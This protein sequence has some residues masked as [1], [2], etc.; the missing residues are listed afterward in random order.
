MS[1]NKLLLSITASAFLLT[2]CGPSGET[3]SQESEPG[4]QETSSDNDEIISELEERI[5]DLEEANKELE[6]ENA[7]LSSSESDEEDGAEVVEAG[8]PE[9]PEADDESS[10]SSENAGTRS[11]PIVF[12][13]EASFFGTFADRDADY[14][15]FDAQVDITVVDTIRGEEA[16]DI[17]INENQFNDPAPEGK[18]YMI[19]RIR[20]KLSNATSDD[21]K[22][23]FSYRDFDY[24]SSGGSSYSFTSVVLPDE[25][26][27]ELYNEGEAEGNIVNLVDID[28]SPL[29][30]FDSSFFFETE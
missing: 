26:S 19:N 12:G 20:I 2:A 13:E 1:M 29:V 24:V 18:E 11:D 17:I 6:E 23:Q 3:S 4:A 9:E 22:A 16:W 15:E 10:Q 5:A 8:E 28:D 27:F 14:E 7:R 30:R 25:L 21:L